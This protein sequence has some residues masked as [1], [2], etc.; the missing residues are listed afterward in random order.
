MTPAGP[1]D[2]KL[3]QRLLAQAR[4]YWPYILCIFLLEL[5]A[6]ALVLLTPLPLKLAVDSVVGAHPLPDFL[7]ALL[8]DAVSRSASRES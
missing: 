7:A 2:L 4:P 8:P 5:L 6:S 3:Y 1:S